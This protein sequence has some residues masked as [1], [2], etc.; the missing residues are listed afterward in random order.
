MW[1]RH[2]PQ[3]PWYWQ[4]CHPSSSSF[5]FH[6]ILELGPNYLESYE[7]R[8]NAVGKYCIESLRDFQKQ[9]NSCSGYDSEVASIM[10][11]KTPIYENLV[12]SSKNRIQ[13]SMPL[14]HPISSLQHPIS[15]MQH[16]LVHHPISTV[17]HPIT[18]IHH[19]LSGVQHPISNI[20]PISSMHQHSIL[21][22]NNPIL[23][24]PMVWQPQQLNPPS[25]EYLLS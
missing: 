20:H 7:L 14:Q 24:N 3:C 8:Y 10:S 15:S 25:G 1:I 18:T 23:T 13:H 19:P 4:V 17:Q 11:S 16:P 22:H 5:H 2:I 6:L 9:P 21:H 12:P